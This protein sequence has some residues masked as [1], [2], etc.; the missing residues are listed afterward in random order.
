MQ[1]WQITANEI[2]MHVTSS[3]PF[4]PKKK[5]ESVPVCSKEYYFVITIQAEIEN[6]LKANIARRID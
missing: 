4:R 6:L 1:H 3:F 5:N 2:C